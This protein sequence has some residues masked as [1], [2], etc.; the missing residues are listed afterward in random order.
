MGWLDHVVTGSGIGHE[1]KIHPFAFFQPHG[2]VNDL[3][4]G[5]EISLFGGWVAQAH[6]GERPD[7]KASA[8]E[9]PFG[10]AGAHFAQFLLA[11]LRFGPKL[12]LTSAQ[13]AGLRGEPL[14]AAEIGRGHIE[15][16]METGKPN[17][18]RD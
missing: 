17:Q 12:E 8:H 14:A 18:A 6:I 13:R 3:I 10:I 9:I 1:E 5:L 11:Q 2:F 15:K 4:H 16:E 7:E